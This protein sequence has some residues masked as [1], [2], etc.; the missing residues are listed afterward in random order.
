MKPVFFKTLLCT[1]LVL[2]SMVF[3]N[4]NQDM[5]AQ[6]YA[7]RNGVSIEEAKKVLDIEMHKDDII[8]LIE[9]EYKGR[10]AGIY[11][12]N[13]PTYKIVVKLKGN[14]KNQKKEMAVSN[15][16]PNINIPVEFVYGAKSTKDVAKGQLQKA[17]KLAQQYL[18]NVQM[19]SYNERT[20]KIDIEIKGENNQQTQDKINQLQKAWKNP[21]LDLNVIFVNYSI[22]T[23]SAI[24]HGGTHVVDK[25]VQVNGKHPICT[26]AFGIKDSKGNKYMSTAAHCPDNFEEK[27]GGVKYTFVGEVPYS[28]SND[29]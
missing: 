2:S 8:D 3:A 6:E 26:T 27:S 9:N 1:T 5:D 12:E 28:K 19:V 14:G 15:A 16:L 13:Q 17:Q 22:S 10:L 4:E 23:M 7:T 21:H 18:D 11:I 20:G 24:A 29:L 25:T